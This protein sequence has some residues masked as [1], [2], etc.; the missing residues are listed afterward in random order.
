MAGDEEEPSKKASLVYEQSEIK[1]LVTRDQFPPGSRPN[2][3]A[4]ETS[5]LNKDILVRLFDV[6]CNVYR[7][8]WNQSSILLKNMIIMVLFE[9]NT[10]T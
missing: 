10:S 3:I 6:F 7:T 8:Q 5:N 4:L 1:S 9:S 2:T